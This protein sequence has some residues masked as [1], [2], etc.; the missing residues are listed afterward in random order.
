MDTRSPQI[1][2]DYDAD[3]PMVGP[4][5]DDA[6]DAEFVEHALDAEA[7]G[8]GGAP[9]VPRNLSSLDTDYLAPLTIVF[10]RHGVTDMTATHRLSGSGVP[11]PG[12]NSTGRIQAAKAADAVYRIGRDTWERVPK[13]SRVIASPMVRTQETAAALGRRLGLHVETDERLKEIDF[14]TWEGLTPEETIERDGRQI[15]LWQDASVRTP[16]GESIADVGARGLAWVQDL[17][18]A[19]AAD[20]ASE[21]TAVSIA[22]V[23]HAVA[24]KATIGAVMGFPLER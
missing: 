10:V 3:G 23:S 19:H 12:L 8:D 18:R 22:A 14:G 9:R 13:V 1:A 21:H 7:D 16:E 24:I 11:G 2:R 6:V 15:L 17:A 4:E 20:P 5:Y